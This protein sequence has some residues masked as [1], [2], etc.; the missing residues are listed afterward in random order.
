MG[1]IGPRSGAADHWFGKKDAAFSLFG[2]GQGVGSNPYRIIFS[3]T[4]RFL[5]YGAMG[6]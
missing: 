6:L 1:V 3:L 4:V 5:F 2:G